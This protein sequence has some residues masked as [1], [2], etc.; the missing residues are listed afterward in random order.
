MPTRSI[1]NR[2]QKMKELRLKCRIFSSSRL[3]ILLFALLWMIH[4]Q[5]TSMMEYNIDATRCPPAQHFFQPLSRKWNSR[6][7][8]S[9]VQPTQITSSRAYDIKNIEIGMA[10]SQT[11][12]SF[13]ILLS[14]SDSPSIIK[15]ITAEAFMNLSRLCLWWS[16]PNLQIYSIVAVNSGQ[17][18]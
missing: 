9:L 17:K 12:A 14:K 16:I 5:Q 11:G 10:S 1:I 7:L 13:E 6:F 15:I 4:S 2:Q 8:I 18:H 3:P